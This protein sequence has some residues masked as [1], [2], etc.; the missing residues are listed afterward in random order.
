MAGP[1]A[2][3]AAAA[4]AASRDPAAEA[5]IASLMR[6]VTEVRRFRSDQGLRPGQQVPAALT[7]IGSTALAGHEG[8]IRAL[9]RLSA[10]GPEF[11]P[12]RVAWWP[13]T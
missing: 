9:L 6:L 7:G 3:A 13:R 11:R 12:D 1:A 10:P 4:A 2:G 5:E 8:S